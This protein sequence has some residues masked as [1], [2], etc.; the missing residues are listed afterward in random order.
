MRIRK[1]SPKGNPMPKFFNPDSPLMR[2]LTKLADLMILNLL[3]LLSCIPVATIGAAWTALYYVTMKMVRDEEDSIVRGFFRAFRRNWKQ[4]TIL[5]LM[6]LG[7]G[8]VIVLDIRFLNAMGDSATAAAMKT[9]V[10]IL[11]VLG[12]MVLQYLFPGLARFE[13]STGNTLKNACLLAVGNLPKTL[14]LS[15]AAVGAV[16]LSCWSNLTISVAIVVWVLMGFA[17]MA[18]GNSGVLVKIFDNCL[19]GN[20][21]ET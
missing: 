6:V 9:A 16:Y 19:P 21:N 10:E 4:A 12:L 13:A 8:A 14:L 11:G 18:Y 2:F 3:F 7:L 5:W 17:L 1:L 15:G 20:K